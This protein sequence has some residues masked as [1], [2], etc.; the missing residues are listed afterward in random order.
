MEYIR[1]SE[2]PECIFHKQHKTLYNVFSPDPAVSCVADKQVSNREIYILCSI[3]LHF[4]E[5][6]VISCLA[7]DAFTWD[8]WILL[9]AILLGFIFQNYL[10]SIS[11]ITRYRCIC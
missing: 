5:E 6:F 7:M 1:G 2:A 3:L 9:A 4:I 11:L 8:K 10:G